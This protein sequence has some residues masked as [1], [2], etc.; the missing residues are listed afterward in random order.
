MSSN[1]ITKTDLVDTEIVDAEEL[2][3][4][5][6]FAYLTNV[7]LVS[8][9]NA[10]STIVTSGISLLYEIDHPIE[11]GDRVYLFG[12]ITADGYY[13]V[14][15]ILSDTDFTVVEA[16][17]NS[18]AGYVDFMHPAGASK[19]GFDPSGQGAI[20]ATNIQDALTQLSNNTINTYT[21]ENL[22]TLV[23]NIAEDGYTVLTYG[24]LCDLKI[25]NCT[26][27]D[28]PLMLFKIRESQI[29]YNCGKVIQIITT[30]YNEVGSPIST[31]TENINYIGN[32]IVSI[33]SSKT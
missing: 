13:T 22:D 1:K 32:N 15:Q 4:D 17:N 7:P 12:T 6:Y 18:V 8:T 14:D 26:T 11:S 21:H 3:S 16:I 23:H 31:L 30:Q 20:T 9:I 24:G 19:V 27:W 5:G 33:T 10:T 2:L 29:T 25:T 28:S